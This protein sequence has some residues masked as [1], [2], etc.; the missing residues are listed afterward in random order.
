VGTVIEPRQRVVSG[1]Y[2][3]EAYLPQNPIA[4]P[5]KPIS[6]WKPILGR[7]LQHQLYR[8]HPKQR[9][10]ICLGI[11]DVLQG[12]K[13]KLSASP[14][15]PSSQSTEFVGKKCGRRRIKCECVVCIC[16]I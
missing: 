10:S 13:R 6:L 4:H 8:P 5:T 1:C 9:R 11:V 2:F 14:S 16:F 7:L 15:G 3:F 12:G